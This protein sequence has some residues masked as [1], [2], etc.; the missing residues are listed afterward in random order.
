VPDDGAADAL[1]REHQ[2]KSWMGSGAVVRASWLPANLAAV[3]GELHQAK[4]SVG[5]TGR[6]VVGAGL[7]TIDGD[8]GTQARVIARLRQSPVLGNVVV[9]RGSADLKAQVDVWGSMGDRVS[10][11]ASVKRALDPHNTLNAGRGP[12]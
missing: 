6:A 11:L 4:A 3:L 7:I 12:L 10:L 1:W 9:L 2:A 5:L 8:V